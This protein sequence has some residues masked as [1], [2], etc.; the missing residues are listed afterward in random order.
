MSW[1]LWG[2]GGREPN[3]AKKCLERLGRGSQ[4]LNQVLKEKW[5]LA[6]HRRKWRVFRAEVM[7]Y[8]CTEE[9]EG[10]W[11]SRNVGG[12]RGRE[13]EWED[14]AD[15]RGVSKTMV[16]VLGTGKSH[17]TVINRDDRGSVLES[18]GSSL[19]EKWV[20]EQEWL[21]SFFCF[22]NTNS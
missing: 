18:L 21:L 14:L 3:A 8:F 16:F 15:G 11:Q 6:K 13:G 20:G 9:R 19:E 12:R 5:N 17:Q 2:L 4:S 1:V 10:K 22:P 7:T